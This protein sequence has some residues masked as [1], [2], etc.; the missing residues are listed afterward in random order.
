MLINRFVESLETTPEP[1]SWKALVACLEELKLVTRRYSKKQIKWIKNRF[2]G[3][4]KRELPQ[5]FA[6]DTSDITRWDELV[7]QPALDAVLSYTNDREFALK[8]LE[9]FTRLS[10]GLN[11]EVSINCPDCDRVFIGEYQW[12]LHLKSNK[13]KR[14]RESRRKKAK[15]ELDKSDTNTSI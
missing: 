14:T 6:L 4:D 13:H 3:S 15:L 2:L 7:S 8:P 1:D 10:E 5:V 12:Q 9:K 11:E